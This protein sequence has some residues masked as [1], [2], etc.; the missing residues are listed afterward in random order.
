MFS[1]NLLTKYTA[2]AIARTYA[3]EAPATSNV[4]KLQFALPHDTLFARKEIYQANLPIKSGQIGVLANHVPIVEQLVPGVVE[5]FENA[6]T[7]KKYFVSGGFASVQPD[8]T[9]TVTAAEAFPLEQFD[10][11]AV[12]SLKD[13]AKKNI[14][15]SDEKVAAEANIQLEVL[16]VLEAALK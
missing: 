5:I 15:S 7:S 14:S 2:K 3:T 4:L 16:E 13:E 6:N 12:R 9:L 11:S 1:R 8:S 10:P